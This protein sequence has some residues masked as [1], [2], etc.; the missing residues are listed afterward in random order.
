M[1]G[2]ASLLHI[3]QRLLVELPY[4]SPVTASNIVCVDNQLRLSKCPCGTAQTDIAAHL[5][6]IGA[7]TTR[8]NTDKSLKAPYGFVIQNLLKQFPI[9]AMGNPMCDLDNIPDLL[10]F[11]SDGHA[12]QF[13]R[14]SF[15]REIEEKGVLLN[16]SRQAK[17]PYA[18]G[19]GIFDL[20]LINA[21]ALRIEL[22][23]RIKRKGG[24]CGNVDRD[25]T[26]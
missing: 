6:R 9:G 16:T 7:G 15:A 25:G 12:K 18:Y 3:E 2:D 17:S 11:R 19:A 24:S 1:T 23:E 10:L 8:T 26:L 22:R 5:L 14:G 21:C 4:C 13:A 20:Y